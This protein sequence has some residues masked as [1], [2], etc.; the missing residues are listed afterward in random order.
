MHIRLF[1]CLCT[2]LLYAGMAQTIPGCTDRAANN[3]NSSATAN[4]GSCS[5]YALSV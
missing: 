3:F 4:N 5:Y 2:A 1:I